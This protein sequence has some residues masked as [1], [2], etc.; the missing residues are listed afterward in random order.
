MSQHCFT[1]DNISLLRRICGINDENIRKIEKF[2]GASISLRGNTLSVENSDDVSENI[3]KIFHILSDLFSD[4]EE[5][6]ELTDFDLRYM[7]NSI[8]N[9]KDIRP[10]DLGKFKFVFSETRKTILP[11]TYN[12]ALYVKAIH[13]NPITFGIGP[14][15]TGKTY[16]AV[17]MALSYF[18]KGKTDKIV[19]TRPAVEAGENLGFLPGDLVAKI[20]PYLRPLYDSLFD[21]LPIEKISKLIEDGRIEIAPLA[22]MRGRTLNKSM[23]ILDEAQNTTKSQMKMFLTRLGDNSKIIVTGD[24][25]QIDIKKSTESGLLHARKILKNIEG[26]SFNIFTKEDISRHP[27]VQKIVAAYEKKTGGDE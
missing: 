25:T 10:S 5:N 19:L 4:K 14:A 3:I 20:N 1:V 17:V 13:D 8:S 22:Y 15:G 23:I 24:I 18:L 26:I 2:S 21:L 7:V 9:N 11:K 16:L 27:I 12:Q 6:Y